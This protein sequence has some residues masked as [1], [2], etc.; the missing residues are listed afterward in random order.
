[1]TDITKISGSE[2]NYNEQLLNFENALVRQL[3][4]LGLPSDGVLINTQERGVV[5]FN[6]PSVVGLLEASKR[7]DSIYIA[8]FLAA[9]ASGLFDAALNYLWDE[10]ILELRKRVENYDIDYFYDIAV[11]SQKKRADLKD[12]SDL[13]KISDAE[14]IKGARE[15]ELISKIGFRLLDEIKYM[16]NWMS[17]AHPNQNEITGL[18]LITW[19]QTCIREVINLPLSNIASNISQLLANIKRNSFSREEIFMMAQ[20]VENARPE[21][22]DTLIQGLYGIY[23]NSDTTTQ[24][25]QNINNLAPYVWSRASDDVKKRIGVRLATNIASGNNSQT[26]MGRSFFEVVQGIQYLPEPILVAEMNEALIN[27]RNAHRNMDNFYNEP[28]FA[29]ELQRI[30]GTAKTVPRSIEKSYVNTIVE[31]FLTNGNG[32][33]F[34]ANP[35]YISLIRRFDER[36][37]MLAML[38]YT[39]ESIA[40][41]LQFALSREKFKELL[42]LI[43]PN[44]TRS[45]A[46][47]FA[48]HLLSERVPLDKISSDSDVR[49]RLENVIALVS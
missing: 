30:V 1:M 40:S 25:I 20:F 26:R 8:K 38:S 29:S 44:L 24:S 32:V 46:I 41:K 2:L 4:S 11:D 17:A 49:R 34:G 3:S 22:I 15:I 19:L 39:S 43:L 6:A 21:Q 23:V 13:D 5:F 14:L 28:P 42:N 45:P 16:R 7:Q 48:N 27:L 33:A 10:T 47:E 31:A 37:S 35:I 12:A 18:Q 9:V 36:L